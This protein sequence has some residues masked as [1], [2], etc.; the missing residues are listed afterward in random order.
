MQERTFPQELFDAD[1]R[2]A[3]DARGRFMVKICDGI[4]ISDLVQA[5]EEANA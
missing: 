3:D 2:S 1:L 5:H 4:R